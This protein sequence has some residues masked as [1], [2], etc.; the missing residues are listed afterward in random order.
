MSIIISLPFPPSV[1]VMYRRGKFSTY[2][3]RQGR[4]YK[5][6]VCELVAEYQPAIESALAGR[7]SVFLGMSAP[8][9]RSY[10]I[11]NRVKVVLD[12]LQDAGVIDDDEQIDFLTVRRLPISKGGYCN[13]VVSQDGN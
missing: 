5:Q 6:K 12:S 7:L 9:R 2:L 11:D 4:D 1:N 8:T 10:D 13:V 3:S